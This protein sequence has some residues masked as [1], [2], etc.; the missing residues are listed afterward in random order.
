MHSATLKKNNNRGSIFFQN[1]QNKSPRPH[2]GGVIKKGKKKWLE[3][4]K[5]RCCET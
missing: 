1:L 4:G 2:G 5:E 3:D